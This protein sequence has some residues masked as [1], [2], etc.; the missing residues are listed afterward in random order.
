MT[1]KKENF[2]WTEGRFY[3]FLLPALSNVCIEIVDGR[4]TWM[5]LVVNKTRTK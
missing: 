5:M 1:M 4:M 2:L 3:A